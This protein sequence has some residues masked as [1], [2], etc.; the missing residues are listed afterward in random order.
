MILPS[1]RCLRDYKIYIQPQ[2]GFNI[3][4]VNALL[5]KAK[6]FSDNESMGY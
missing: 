4:I 3:D 5:E 2:R 1:R 6:H